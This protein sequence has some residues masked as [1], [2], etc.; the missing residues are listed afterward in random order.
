MSC[1]GSLFMTWA[2]PGFD[3]FAY[4]NAVMNVASSPVKA[5]PLEMASHRLLTLEPPP[6]GDAAALTHL[7]HEEMN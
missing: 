4:I 2:L 7:R 6:I 5:Q 3:C 1:E